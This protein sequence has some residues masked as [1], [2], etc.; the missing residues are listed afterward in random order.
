MS[1]QT[2]KKQEFNM[3]QAFALWIQKSKAGTQYLSGK[4]DDG[5]RLVGFFN[6]KKQNP[7]EPDIRIYTVNE[8]G[9]TSEEAY[10]SLWANV[11][12]NEKTYFSGKLGETRLVGFVNKKAKI[13]GK[14]P[15]ISVYESDAAIKQKEEKKTD[16]ES[17]PDGVDE[18][19]P[20]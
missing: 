13:G 15:Y 12:K 3:K 18:A 5:Q 11:S 19:L 17:I 16:F 10:T 8:D 6:G 20:F 14:V 1:K 9:K 2:E 4:S 7:K